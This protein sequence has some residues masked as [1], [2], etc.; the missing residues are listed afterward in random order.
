M[1]QHLRKTLAKDHIPATETI[2][3]HQNFVLLSTE[4]MTYIRDIETMRHKVQDEF[5]MVDFKLESIKR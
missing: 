1:L 3:F 4:M 5:K 2:N